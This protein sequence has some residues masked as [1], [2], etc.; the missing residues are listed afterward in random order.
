MEGKGLFTSPPWPRTAPPLSSSVYLFQN[1]KE[2]S[3]SLSLSLSL[4]SLRFAPL[5][6]ARRGRGSSSKPWKDALFGDVGGRRGPAPVHPL[7]APVNF[8]KRLFRRAELPDV[9][10]M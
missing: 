3:L 4:S 8:S 7:G 10:Q 2:G 1:R 9:I 6:M 5:A